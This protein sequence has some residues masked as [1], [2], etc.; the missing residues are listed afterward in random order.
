MDIAQ[1]PEA[2][3][4]HDDSKKPGVAATVGVVSTL[5]H[6]PAVTPTRPTA[7]A[8]VHVVAPESSAK[9]KLGL[10]LTD[11]AMADGVFETLVFS[12]A[13]NGKPV[14][15]GPPRSAADILK[16]G[17]LAGFTLDP[18][19]ECNVTVRAWLTP[20]SPAAAYGKDLSLGVA[21]TAE[22]VPGGDLE[23]TPRYP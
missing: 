5:S 22:S 11:L 21:V 9:V 1:G 18:G 16:S 19:T 13:V 4:Q 10:A 23:L 14:E 8:T 20:M 7:S 17:G 2:A 3:D 15:E 12:V 6:I